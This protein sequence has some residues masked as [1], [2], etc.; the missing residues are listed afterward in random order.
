MIFFQ[1]LPH[2]FVFCV[3]NGLDDEAVVF[4]VV[5]ETATFTRRTKL[6]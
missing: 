4:G 3:M 2:E 1:N 5:E 6:G